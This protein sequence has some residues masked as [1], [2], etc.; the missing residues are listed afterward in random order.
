M[1]H[2]RSAA[3]VTG[4]ERTKA[5]HVK[6]L[7][8]GSLLW[9][10]QAVLWLPHPPLT[11]QAPAAGISYRFPRYSSAD[12]VLLLSLHRSAGQTGPAMQQR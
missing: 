5:A 2:S 4:R 1:T 11:V 8:T 12:D 10:F 7:D 6:F 9:A 3:A